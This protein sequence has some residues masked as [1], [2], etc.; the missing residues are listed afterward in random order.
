MRGESGGSL[1]VDLL[2]VD[3]FDVVVVGVVVAFA[4]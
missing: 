4:V 2:L 1:T 3:G